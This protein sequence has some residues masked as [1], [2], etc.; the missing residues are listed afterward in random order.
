MACAT[1][2]VQIAWFCRERLS[3]PTVLDIERPWTL[4]SA[5]SFRAHSQA[6]RCGNSTCSVFVTAGFTTFTAVV[7]R[8]IGKRSSRRW[9]RCKLP[10]GVISKVSRNN[11]AGSR[12]GE[13]RFSPLRG[14][15]KYGD[16]D[17][18]TFEVSISDGV[19]LFCE[20]A[21]SA[22]LKPSA[23]EPDAVA[24]STAQVGPGLIRIRYNS[25]T[26]RAESQYRA[27]GVA[28][29]GAVVEASR[30]VSASGLSRQR[31]G[32][33]GQA[34]RVVEADRVGIRVDEQGLAEL[35][36]A[37]G[38]CQ[39]ERVAVLGISGALRTGKSFFFDLFSRYLHSSENW[40]PPVLDRHCFEWQAGAERCTEGIWIWSK[41]FVM[42]SSSG[43]RTAVLLMD[44]QGVFDARSTRQQCNSILG[45]TAALS[46]LLVYNVSRQLQQDTVDDLLAFLEFARGTLRKNSIQ[47]N[48]TSSLFGSLTF[49]V[50]D[51]AHL[52]DDF[53]LRD[54][55]IQKTKVLGNFVDGSSS[56]ADLKRMFSSLDCLLVPPPGPIDTPGWSGHTE[57]LEPQFINMCEH[58]FQ[59]LLASAPP[60]SVLGEPATP[61]SFAGIVR[62]LVPVFADRAPRV[63]SFSEALTSSCEMLAVRRA[64]EEY[65]GV[66]KDVGAIGEVASPGQLALV[67]EAL[68]TAHARAVEQA[69]D[70]LR[71]QL[72]FSRSQDAQLLMI[73]LRSEFQ[74]D[75]E[76]RRRENEW[77]NERLLNRYAGA[78]LASFALSIVAP[79]LA[80]KIALV[81]VPFLSYQVWR[82]QKEGGDVASSSVELHKEMLRTERSW[83]EAARAKAAEA[84]QSYST[85]LPGLATAAEA[86][87]RGPHDWNDAAS[88]AVF[89]ALGPIPEPM[90]DAVSAA[91]DVAQSGIK[92]S[93]EAV[94]ESAQQAQ[95]NGFAEQASSTVE[96]FAQSSA[97]AFFRCG[98]ELWTKRRV[99]R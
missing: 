36:E 45:L 40:L 94:A 93:W 13:L 66:M 85:Q 78:S 48:Y 50:R 31:S 90:A 7:V 1:S 34:L 95:K 96:S 35:E 25:Y 14:R 64:R 19:L 24:W 46:S 89:A 22:E 37:L 38:C 3:S 97:E 49:L 56:G 73:E 41:P 2:N 51:W 87:S 53:P 26:G 72:V 70:I 11:G 91:A 79:A 52:S 59:A 57:V 27:S 74:F 77:H 65:L 88:S 43:I 55:E 58:H 81:S 67:D 75:L 42:V 86:H 47:C 20:G 32:D 61:T 69:E 33:R 29:W 8:S 82:L 76:R 71:K 80:P 6:V 18:E 17:K 5:L 16:L 10:R 99:A 44:T 12:G 9:R 21:V 30:M 4:R 15:W 84:L 28:E 68:D 63:V 62:R 39:C 83:A 54:H 98:R 92:A 60:L 23:K